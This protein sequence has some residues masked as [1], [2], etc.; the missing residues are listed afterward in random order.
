MVDERTVRL[1]LQGS[2]P[3]LTVSLVLS[4]DGMWKLGHRQGNPIRLVSASSS[5]CFHCCVGFVST[6]C[7]WVV[8]IS[9]T[10]INTLTAQK[11]N[12]ILIPSSI[13]YSWTLLE[14]LCMSHSSYW[15]VVCLSS[16]IWG[17]KKASLPDWLPHI[18]K[19]FLK[20]V[21]WGCTADSWISTLTDIIQNQE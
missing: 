9:W 20:H 1:L 4:P 13:F 14:L 8:E 2:H 3:E 17:T 11:T 10:H 18:N 16:S 15:T 6:G 12:L 7:W 21:R 5:A 19:R